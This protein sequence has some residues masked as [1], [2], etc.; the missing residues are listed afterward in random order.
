M[1][2][3]A[4]TVMALVAILGKKARSDTNPTFWTY[5]DYHCPC[6]AG[7]DLAGNSDCALNTFTE[8]P[9]G[10][11]N[12]TPAHPFSIFSSFVDE[13]GNCYIR[14]H[15]SPNCEGDFEEFGIEG[16]QGAFGKYQSDGRS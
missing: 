2:L 8:N 10:I 6:A 14:T 1:K 16:D 12:E 5:G 15:Y 9:E 4:I 13:T 3:S 7:N 11:C